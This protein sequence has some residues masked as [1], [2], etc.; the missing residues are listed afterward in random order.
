LELAIMAFGHHKWSLAGCMPENHVV[1]F[2]NLSLSPFGAQL[3]EGV[4]GNSMP[5]V[6]QT[7]E[8]PHL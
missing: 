4:K 8:G 7:E 5:E 6:A 2:K 1:P 3:L